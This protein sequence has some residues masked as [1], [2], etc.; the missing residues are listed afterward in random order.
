MYMYMYMYMY[1]YDESTYLAN[2]TNTNRNV[3]IVA[4]PDTNREV[5]PTYCLL[6]AY[7]VILL[8]HMLYV[9]HMAESLL[10]SS[11]AAVSVSSKVTSV[12]AAVTYPRG[13]D[14][15]DARYWL[16]SLAAGTTHKAATVTAV[17][18]LA[19]LLSLSPKCGVPREHIVTNLA[20]VRC[21]V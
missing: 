11:S 18:S 5:L 8:L 2:T 13:S 10:V 7:Y 19:E 4:Q 21:I 9:M 3:I 20:A 15:T 1:S 14:E 12:E 16:P 17:V 6:I